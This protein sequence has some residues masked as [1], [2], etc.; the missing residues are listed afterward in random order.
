MVCD[1]PLITPSQSNIDI[2]MEE[3]TVSQYGTR[4]WNLEPL[5]HHDGEPL[6]WDPYPVYH[7][8]KT[9]LKMPH[10]WGRFPRDIYNIMHELVYQVELDCGVQK[11]CQTRIILE[12]LLKKKY[13]HSQ[14]GN[15]TFEVGPMLT[16]PISP[17]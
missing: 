3:N 12:M 1:L 14:L 4:T 2:I 11:A 7:G 6:I 9:K 16:R 13:V 17:G 15:L 5:D 8:G 10:L